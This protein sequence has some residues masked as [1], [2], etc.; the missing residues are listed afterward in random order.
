MSAV[1]GCGMCLDAHE[2][3]LRKHSVTSVQVQAALRIAATVN[4]VSAVLRAE[5]AA[6]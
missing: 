2:A 1:N 6:V 5:A 4:A 3:E